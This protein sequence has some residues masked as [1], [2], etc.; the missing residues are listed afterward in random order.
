MKGILK[1]KAKDHFLH[2]L[3]YEINF[4]DDFDTLPL[5]FQTTL[6]IEWFDSKEQYLIVVQDSRDWDCYVKNE[7][8]GASLKNRVECTL[9]GLYY[10]IEKYNEL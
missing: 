6:L 4:N 3:K 7:W 5:M 2:W 1:G 8:I 9:H 10:L